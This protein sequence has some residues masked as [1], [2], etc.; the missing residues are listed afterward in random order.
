MIPK[1]N[2]MILDTIIRLLAGF[3]LSERVSKIAAPFVALLAGIVL[4]SAL[5]GLGWGA[6][7]VFDYFNDRDA[8]QRDRTEREAVEAAAALEAERRATAAEAV[9]Q[10]ERTAA[11]AETIKQLEEIEDADPETAAGPAA[12][13]SRTVADRLRD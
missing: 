13:G 8:I 6:W 2:P 3:G 10:G 9:R 4:L 5:G 12:A 1:S 7:Q 11:S